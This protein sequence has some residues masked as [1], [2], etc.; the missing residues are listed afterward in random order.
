MLEVTRFQDARSF[1]AAGGGTLYHNEVVNSLILGVVERLVDKPN[2]YGADTPYLGLVTDYDKTL[3]AATI[4][5][6]FGLLLAPL[7]EDVE[8]ALELVLHN[9]QKHTVPYP[10]V[11]ALAPTA[12]RFAQMW[13]AETGGSYTLEMRQRVYELRKVIP[14]EGVSGSFRQAVEQDA[15][16]IGT[17]LRSFEL[18]CF[19]ITSHSLEEYQQAAL[20]RIQ[21]GDWFLWEADD[22]WVVSMCMRVRPTS[23]GCSVSGVYTPPEYRG[24]GYA[25]ACVAAL[26]QRLLD[27]GYQF[28]SLF[29]DLANPTSNS[30][31]M[32]VGYVPRADFVKIKLGD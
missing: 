14:A 31:Y 16:L 26:S 4:T 24:K 18:D 5:P 17:W 13:A 3:L 30:I 12:E 6:P 28:T 29:T 22:R 25:S 32:K 27:E 19:G 1:L 7:V 23:H 21:H 9:L 2:F 20:R 10:D 8:M 11:H 15:P